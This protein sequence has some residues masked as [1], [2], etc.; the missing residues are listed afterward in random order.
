[1]DIKD[2]K[3]NNVKLVH[4]FSSQQQ[5][6]IQLIIECAIYLSPEPFLI[7]STGNKTKRGNEIN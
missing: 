6:S 5:P 7:N 1:M 3:M 2:R 4:L